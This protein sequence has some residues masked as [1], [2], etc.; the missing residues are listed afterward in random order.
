MEG[1]LNG[2]K[3]SHNGYS[4]AQFQYQVFK[5]LLLMILLCVFLNLNKIIVIC[6]PCIL[7]YFYLMHMYAKFD[8][9]IPSC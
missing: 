2:Q 4:C 7:P 1:K 3:C 8:Q 5:I 9:N 6:D